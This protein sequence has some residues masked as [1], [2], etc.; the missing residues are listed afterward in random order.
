MTGDGKTTPLGVHRQRGGHHH[1]PR[2]IDDNTSSQHADGLTASIR[3]SSNKMQSPS[4]VG[5]CTATYVT[6]Q[7]KDTSI[8]IYVWQPGLQTGQPDRLLT[9]SVIMSDHVSNT[10]TTGLY[11][12]IGDF[13]QYWIAD[14][15]SMQVQRLS[16]RT[17]KRIKSVTVYGSDER[18]SSRKPSPAPSFR[19]QPLLTV[20]FR[21]EWAP[22]VAQCFFSIYTLSLILERFQ[23]A[24]CNTGALSPV[25]A[26]T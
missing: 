9:C 22:V 23:T 13:S 10:F 15:L 26:G 25:V 6:L 12:G 7:A 20:S 3:S 16:F 14:S 5:S 19:L 8:G 4:H 24:T 11:V 18:P 17:P 21:S 2:R 1:G